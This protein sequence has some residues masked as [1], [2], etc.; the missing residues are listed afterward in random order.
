MGHCALDLLLAADGEHVALE[1]EAAEL[2]EFCGACSDAAE[3]EAA[4]LRLC[5]IY[6]IIA[7]KDD[8]QRERR[9]L[10]ILSGLGFEIEKTKVPIDML[11]GGWRMRAMLAAALFMEPELL[12]LDE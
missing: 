6:D 7:E 8:G 1:Q 5:E 12:L 11:S 10:K 4:G 9:A 2:E 3:V